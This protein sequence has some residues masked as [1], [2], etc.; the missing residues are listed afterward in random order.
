MKMAIALLTLLS[1]TAVRYKNTTEIPVVSY[2]NTGVI[3]FFLPDLPPWVSLSSE[4]KC[5]LPHQRRFMDFQSIHEQ[6]QLTHLEMIELQL[7]FNEKWRTLFTNNPAAIVSAQEESQLFY[8]TLERVR[9]GVRRLKYPQLPGTYSVFWK[10]GKV[11]GYFKENSFL[12][13]LCQTTQ[14]LESYLESADHQGYVPI[15]IGYDALTIF[16]DNQWS[17]N[18]YFSFS[19]FLIGTEAVKLETE[20]LILPSEFID[21]KIENKKNIN[22]R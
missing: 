15:P 7:Q 9:A 20:E 16:S 2:Q 18:P 10:E 8:E 22:K 12:F 14:E 3:R 4:G 19:P 13:S 17:K 21:L 1:C 6:Y 5:F 11:Q